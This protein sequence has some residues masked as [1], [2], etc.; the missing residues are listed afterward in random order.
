MNK[1]EIIIQQVKNSPDTVEFKDVIN[2]IDESYDYEPTRFTNGSQNE[3]VINPAGENEG[4]CKIFSFAK[5][6][7][8]NVEQTL[9]C[10]G[11]YYRDEVLNHPERSDHQNIRTFIKYGWEQLDFEGTALKEI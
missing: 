5:I 4:S 7:N 10:F 11:H 9:N 2:A 6:N 1:I 3:K 8:L